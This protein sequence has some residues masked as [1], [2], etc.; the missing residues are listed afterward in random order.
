MW[1]AHSSATSSARQVALAGTARSGT[2]APMPSPVGSGAKRI[3]LASF[4]HKRICIPSVCGFKNWIVAV[5]LLQGGAELCM[6]TV[7]SC[8]PSSGVA[9]A[10]K[11]AEISLRHSRLTCNPRRKSK[12]NG[13]E[14]FSI[15]SSVILFC[16]AT[17]SARDAASALRCSRLTIHDGW[18]L[19]SIIDGKFIDEKWS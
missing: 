17:L 9:L 7:Y 13:T 5:M 6:I 1:F 16:I 15:S 4:P 12:Q 19:E 10:F 2:I 14:C 18:R 8:A 3:Y 11:C